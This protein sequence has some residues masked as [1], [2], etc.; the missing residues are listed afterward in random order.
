MKIK[1][2]VE[3]VRTARVKPRENREYLSLDKTVSVFRNGSVLVECRHRFRF[4]AEMTTVKVPHTIWRISKDLPEITELRSSNAPNGVVRP[5]S[6]TPGFLR[7][8][9]VLCG[10]LQAQGCRCRIV[11][12]PATSLTK[13]ERNFAVEF[14]N[15]KVKPGD[16]LMYE[17]VWSYPNAFSSCSKISSYPNSVGV[18]T[19]ERGMAQS[20]SLTLKFERVLDDDHIEPDRILEEPPTVF[21]TDT[22]LLPSNQDSE[23]F[24]H[25]SPTWREVEKLTA[26][27]KKSGAMFE[28]YRWNSDCFLGMAKA[29]WN[30]HMNYFQTDSNPTTSE[31]SGGKQSATTKS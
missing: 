10:P 18:R 24:W 14:T 17:I 11:P 1:A 16:E 27:P 7:C 22:T 5:A 20:S 13:N 2:I 31:T 3:N 30:T 29:V 21:H 15:V 8:F 12:T 23:S 6:A 4:T 26:C 9:P 28:V 25:L 19:G